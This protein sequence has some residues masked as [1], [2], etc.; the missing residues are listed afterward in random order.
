MSSIN[1]FNALSLSASLASAAF[2]FPYAYA[3]PSEEERSTVNVVTG[4]HLVTATDKNH[5]TSESTIELDKPDLEG[6]TEG[7]KPNTESTE[8]EKPHMETAEGEKLDGALGTT[9]TEGTETEKPKTDE[10]EKPKTDETEKP[11]TDEIEKP[12]TDETGKLVEGSQGG[13]PV[14][15]QGTQGGVPVD[16]QVGVPVDPQGTQGASPIDPPVTSTIDNVQ[17]TET[18]VSAAPNLSMSHILLGS[19]FF[20]TIFTSF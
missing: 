9:E 14:D 11:K 6:S 10:T 17:P 13:S 12:K 4:G 8:G 15:P 1:N 2:M 5:P 19:I 7:E 18:P 16:P 3:M 20:A